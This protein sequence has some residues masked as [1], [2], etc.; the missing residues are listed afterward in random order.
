MQDMETR[1]ETAMS[2][3]KYA[4]GQP[5]RRKEDDTLLRGK[6]QYTDDFNMPGQAYAWM[7]ALTRCAVTV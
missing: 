4:V 2:L 5:V 7:V 3:Q 1:A 6:G